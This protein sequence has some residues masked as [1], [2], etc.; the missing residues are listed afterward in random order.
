MPVEGGGKIVKRTM[1]I[2]GSFAGLV[3]FAPL[4]AC[5]ALAIT[6]ESKG[7]IFVRL[8]R[9]S[10]GKEF[11]LY[12]FRSMI[13]NAEAYK[14]QLVGFNERMDGPLFKMKDDPRITRVGRF[15]RKRRFDELP[16][17]INVLRGEISLVGPRPHQP[18]EIAAYQRHH[19]KVLAIKS[20]ITGLAQTS[21]AAN[22]LFEEEVKL[23]RYYVESWSLKKDIIIL[24]RTLW[25]LFF[26]RGGY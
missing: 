7:P 8:R 26:D 18:D 22:L 25:M 14:P 19:K 13:D 16:Q 9:I 23:D 5:V 10:Q 12:K 15:L 24:L 1:D 2:A 17:F 11:A 21:G 4:F 6:L 3:L 20:G